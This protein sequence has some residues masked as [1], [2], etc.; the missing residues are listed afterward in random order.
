MILSENHNTIINHQIMNNLTENEMIDEM[1]AQQN[2]NDQN[3]RRTLELE[4]M[5]ENDAL[6]ECFLQSNQNLRYLKIYVLY[7]DKYIKFWK[8]SK[9][10]DLVYKLNLLKSLEIICDYNVDRYFFSGLSKLHIFCPDILELKLEIKVACKNEA[11]KT[12][13]YLRN[14]TQLE[15]LL[16]YIES[17]NRIDN[18]LI[19]A[20]L[21]SEFKVLKRLDLKSNYI[22]NNQ[23]I[24]EIPETLSNLQEL[25]IS[26]ISIRIDSLIKLLDLNH[27]KKLEVNTSELELLPKDVTLLMGA[28]KKNKILESL[29]VEEGYIYKINGKKMLFELN[30]EE[31]K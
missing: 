10:F 31:T 5:E 13:T 24:C 12:I 4:F 2:E 30:Q 22:F 20:H 6:I 19:P 28:I 1:I 29:N 9:V 27:L 15:S 25:K 23:F 8:F 21:F 16:L 7:E 11:I 18:N 3:C 26:L 14:I 17:D